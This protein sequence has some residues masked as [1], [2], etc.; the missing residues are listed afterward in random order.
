MRQV[1]CQSQPVE[2]CLKSAQSLAQNPIHKL[3]LITKEFLELVHQN[4][5]IVAQ[6]TS[7]PTKA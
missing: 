5:V 6:L 2:S 3:T 4:A 1:H 7:T